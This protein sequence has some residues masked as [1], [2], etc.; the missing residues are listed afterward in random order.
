MYPQI[1]AYKYNFDV[2]KGH[3]T[4]LLATLGFVQYILLLGSSVYMT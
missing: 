2:G 1:C 3:H 4:K